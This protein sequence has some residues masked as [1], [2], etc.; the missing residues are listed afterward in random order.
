MENTATDDFQKCLNFL[1]SINI[2]VF[3]R[4]IEGASFL[5]G[6]II[7]NGSIIVDKENLLYPG[8]I[9]HEAGHIACVPAS[10]RSDLNEDNINNRKDNAAEE[11]MAIAWSYA[12]CVHLQLDAHFLFH[13]NGYKGSAAHIADSFKNGHYLGVP[14]L[15][16]VG[17]CQE[18]KSEAEPDKPFYPIM[19]K[20]LRN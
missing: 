13:E 15:Q 3:F 20:W 12:A 18:R 2:P 5:P 11:M 14:M 8:D 9:L 1:E 19:Q 17:L 4:T 16:W 10:E 7:E 6:L